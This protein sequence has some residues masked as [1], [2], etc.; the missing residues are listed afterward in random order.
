M[1]AKTLDIITKI[2]SSKILDNKSIKKLQNQLKKTNLEINAENYATIS[3]NT[4]TLATA[5][6]AA[7]THTLTNDLTTTT[8]ASLVTFTATLL[9]FLNFPKLKAKEKAGEIERE[10]ATTIKTIA[11]ELQLNTP[12]EKIIGKLAKENSELGR[13]FKKANKKIELGNSIPEAL[14]ETAKRIDSQTFQKFT[15]ELIFNYEHGSKQN[16]QTEGLEKISEE[17]INQQK[18]SIREYQAKM[19]ITSLF[20][21]TTSCILPSLYISYAILGN[22]F[23]NLQITA[24]EIITTLTLAFPTANAILLLIIKTQIPK[25][26]I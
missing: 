19:Q 10:L 16:P 2:N 13:E 20:F 15:T 22:N 11:I 14:Q 7:A 17:I 23:L 6:V 9:L 8:I 3:I 4:T 5:I 25:T 26:I 21:I 24:I 1:A 18:N 12:F